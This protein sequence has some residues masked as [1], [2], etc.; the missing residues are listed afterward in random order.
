MTESFVAV[1]LLPAPLR[2]LSEKPVAYHSTAEHQGTKK[3]VDVHVT[4]WNP[5]QIR[6][7]VSEKMH[8]AQKGSSRA[9]VITAPLKNEIVGVSP[10]TFMAIRTELCRPGCNRRDLCRERL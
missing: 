6:R 10:D 3:Q 5:E 2:E 8:S 1:L 9:E 4:P 7:D